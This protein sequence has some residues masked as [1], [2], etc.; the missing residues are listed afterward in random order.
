[1]NSVANNSNMMV[2]TNKTFKS[3]FL[4][5]TQFLFQS[6]DIDT[7]DKI[8]INKNIL[9]E[10]LNM[11]SIDNEFNELKEI[12]NHIKDSDIAKEILGLYS[13][14]FEVYLIRIWD[15]RSMIFLKK[16]YLNQ[17]KMNQ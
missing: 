1:M 10:F 8:I 14:L 9:E 17:S 15:L 12:I 3:S 16:I 5:W 4:I 11:I 6:H 13:F 2:L 7:I